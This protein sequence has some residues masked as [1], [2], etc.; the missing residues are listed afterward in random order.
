VIKRFPASGW[1]A[2]QRTVSQAVQPWEHRTRVS[3]GKG[4]GNLSGGQIIRNKRS[5]LPTHP[6][7]SN[8]V[9]ADAAAI[10][11]SIY[12]PTVLTAAASP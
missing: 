12:P 9:D 3:E 10:T 2:V 8:A 7:R 1:R 11:H 6:T 5:P 4:G